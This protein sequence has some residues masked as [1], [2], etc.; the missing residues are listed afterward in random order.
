MKK[1]RSFTK[2]NA[3]EDRDVLTT[4]KQEMQDSQVGSMYFV[5]CDGEMHHPKIKSGVNGR[6]ILI[7]LPKL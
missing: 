6:F 4:F 2:T 1:S 5:A 3:G 7:E